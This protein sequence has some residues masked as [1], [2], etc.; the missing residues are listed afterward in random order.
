MENAKTATEKTAAVATNVAAKVGNVVGN[1]AWGAKEG[2]KKS[3][4]YR[5]G[6]KVRVCSCML[7][8]Y[9]AGQRCTYQVATTSRTLAC[10]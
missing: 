9:S 7:A 6:G 2:L 3:G 8:W 1:V 10:N 4:A 5:E